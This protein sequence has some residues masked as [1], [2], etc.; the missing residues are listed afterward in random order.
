[1]KF[2]YMIIKLFEFFSYFVDIILSEEV[3]VK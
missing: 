1:M 3:N 2:H